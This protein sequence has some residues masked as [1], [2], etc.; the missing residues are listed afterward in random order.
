LRVVL[1][2]DVWIVLADEAK[3]PNSEYLQ[4][5]KRLWPLARR[6]WFDAVVLAMAGIGVT[7]AIVGRGHE[8]GPEGP[9]W[10]DVLAMLA[11]VLP[12][13]ARRRFPFGAP[14]AVGIAAALI[15]FVDKTV[16]P[17]DGVTF[18]VGCAA[19]FLVGLLRDRAQAVAGFAVAEGVLAVVVHNDPR[20]GVGNFVVASIIF[21][22]VWTIAFGVGRKSVE[23]DEARERAF[24]A[25][26]EREE[27]A[28]SAVAEERARIARELHDVVGHSVSVMTVQASGV[29]RLLRPDQDREREALLV[30]ER[31]GREALAEMRRMV[32]VLR[33]PEEAPALAPQPSLD[34]LNRL[35]DQAREAG[36]PVELRI[37]GEAIQLPAGVDL[38]AYRLVQ[39]G[40]TN[41]VKHA[42]ATRA[43][44]LVNYGDGYLEV[45]VRDDGQGVGNG[46]GGGH[47][48]VGMRERVSVYGGDLD[49]G[50]QPGGGYRLR[51]KL[52]LTS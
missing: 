47:G 6:Y 23:A 28:R 48:L 13:L 45:T 24:R 10:F 4:T 29:R 32:G 31:T 11:I 1:A 18:L 15:S 38:T 43:E 27:R 21:A 51:A 16:V 7:G 40:L 19:L 8:L 52:P 49:A 39:E 36:L 35:V 20:S 34:H 22:I 17:F 26:R 33:R 42:Q 3:R 12:L 37:E 50:P 41:V 46:D 44:V 9:L 30:V 14:A 2:D 5:V 25:E